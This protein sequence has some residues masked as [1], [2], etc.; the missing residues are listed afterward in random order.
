MARPKAKT[1]NILLAPASAD[2]NSLRGRWPVCG[3]VSI[4]EPGSEL[5]GLVG[6]RIVGVEQLWSSEKDLP[7]ASYRRTTYATLSRN[8]RSLHRSQIDA[9][10]SSFLTERVPCPCR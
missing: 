9:C 4:P 2:L 1:L 5:D 3:Y 8:R 6:A 7:I 10:L